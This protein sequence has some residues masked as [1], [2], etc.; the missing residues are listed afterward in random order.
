M[1]CLGFA[2]GPEYTLAA[3]TCTIALSGRTRA[4]SWREGEGR[5]E[6]KRD[7]KEKKGGRKGMGE[8]ETIK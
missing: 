3:G 1:G 6:R 4:E 7:E 2:L 5:N 8:R